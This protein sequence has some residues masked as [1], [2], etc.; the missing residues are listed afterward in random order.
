MGPECE[1]EMVYVADEAGC[2]PALALVEQQPLSPPSPPARLSLHGDHCHREPQRC[3]RVKRGLR[4]VCKYVYE[5]DL[6][7]EK[8]AW[9]PH[10]QVCQSRIQVN[11][12]TFVPTR[13]RWVDRIPFKTFRTGHI[14]TTQTHTHKT[15]AD[16]SKGQVSLYRLDF[17]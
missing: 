4:C 14:A 3:V 1:L 10:F 16:I 5:T 2:H 12:V 11:K 9:A 17:L 8:P 6:Q 7:P 13:I 15:S